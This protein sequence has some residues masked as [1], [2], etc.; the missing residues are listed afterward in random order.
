MVIILIIKMWREIVEPNHA[1]VKV[2]YLD[3][4]KVAVVS[5]NRTKKYNAITYKMF[6]MI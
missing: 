4:G 3:E 1:E 2:T 5:M 6:D